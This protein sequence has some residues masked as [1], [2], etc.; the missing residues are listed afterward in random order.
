MLISKQSALSSRSSIVL[1]TISLLLSIMMG[2]SSETSTTR[3]DAAIEAMKRGDSIEAEKFAR[4]IIRE[5][6]EWNDAQMLLAKIVEGRGDS[7]GVLE[8]FAAVKRDG[9]PLSLRAAEESANTWLRRCQLSKA[10]ENFEY[11]VGSKPDDSSMRSTLASIFTIS[12]QRARAE[13]HLFKL[14]KSGAIEMEDLVTYTQP[15]RPPRQTRLLHQCDEDNNTDPFVIFGLALEDMQ[16]QRFAEA[17]RRTDLVVKAMPEFAEAQALLGELLLD[18]DL[19]AVTQWHEDLPSVVSNSVSI[20]YVRGLWAQRLELDEAA[21]RCFWEVV[22][23]SPTHRKAMYQLGQVL[24]TSHPEAAI[25]F[26]E[27]AEQLHEYSELLEKVLNSAGKDPDQVKRLIELLTLMGRDWEAWAWVGKIEQ[28]SEGE[29]AI[30]PEWAALSRVPSANPP[31][32]LVDRDLTRTYDLSKLP[33]PRAAIA[34]AAAGLA[35]PAAAVGEVRFAN[36]AA[37]VG[38]DFTYFQGPDSTSGGVRIF[39]S[40]G[41]GAGVIDI[42]LDGWP[43]LLLTQGEEWPQGSDQPAGSPKY[44]DHIYRNRGGRFSDVSDVCGLAD[45]DAYSQGCSAGD[46]NNDGFPDLYIANVGRNQL[47]LNNGD[48]TFTDV[49]DESGIQGTSWTTSCLI[50]DLNAD[51]WPDLYDVNYLEGERVYRVECSADRCSVRSFTGA[52]DQ[53]QLSLGDGTFAAVPDAVPKINCK[54]L[55]IVSIYHD[56]D[57]RPSLFIAND[58]VP[59]FYLRPESASGVYSDHAVLSGLAV[60]KDGQPTACMGVASGDPD[61]NGF[62]DLFVTNFEGEANCLYLQNSAGLFR[63]RIA[64]SGLMAAGIPYVGWGTQ[65]IDV[66][67]DG[68]LDI[69]VTNG[70]VADFGEPGVE[71][72]MPSQLFLN[73]GQ[74]QYELVPAERA[75]E[76]FAVAALGRSLATADWNADGRTDFVISNL[77]SPAVIAFNETEVVGRSLDIRLHATQ[78]SRDAVGSVVK[79]KVGDRIISQRLTAGDGYQATNERRLFFGLA[80]NERVDELTVL[81]PSGTTTVLHD[82]PSQGKLHIAEK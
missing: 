10:A 4:T 50:L 40:T 35:Q 56:G 19:N 69:V 58:Q 26:S 49:T 3:M 6:P 38:V 68:D 18:T 71:Y 37:E 51:G 30:Q 15:E 23:K 81:W 54:G 1:S 60:N 44:R 29:M 80:N 42:D 61:Q 76:L 21:A 78:S 67:N 8:Y 7:D 43:D 72:R 33:D 74:N 46:F 59:N 17:R 31:R 65:F 2:C 25:A 13:S 34:R 70:H 11:L 82:I 64:G 41:G 47:L 53:V 32:I 24:Q 5:D 45:N 20:W 48:G 77:A 57:P 73:N 66:E 75:G 79:L 27:R 63:D 36:R 39:E 52:P 22:R 62:T 9:S 28:L 16:S 14:L 12:G 55:G